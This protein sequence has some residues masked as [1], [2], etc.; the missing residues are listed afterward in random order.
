MPR[1]ISGFHKKRRL[2]QILYSRL[3][4]VLLVVAVLFLGMHVWDVL[5]KERSTSIKKKQ[6][7]QELSELKEREELLREEVERLETASGL[8][9]EIRRKFEVGREREGLIIVVDPLEEE[10]TFLDFERQ[11]LW[12]R[13]ISWFARD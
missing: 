8:E 5:Q 12:Q 6:Q 11:S 9:A 13:V 1:N 3:T 7:E 4:I 10:T 2:K